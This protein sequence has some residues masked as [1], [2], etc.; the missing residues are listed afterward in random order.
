MG[1]QTGK[2]IKYAFGEIILVVIG[3]LIAL[4]IN[5]W[6]Q[7][8]KDSKEENQLL[9]KLR[10]NIQSDTTTL[11]RKIEEIQSYLDT[12]NVIESEMKDETLSFF[13]VEISRPLLS[14]VQMNL[15]TT[16]WENL[17]STGKLSLLKNGSLVDSL[18]MYYKQFEDVNKL[19]TEGFQ[20]YNRGILAPRFFELDDFTF[21]SP[22][23]IFNKE[24][25]QRLPPKKYGEN[26][27]FRNAV[28][29]RIGALKSIKNIFQTDLAK[30]I[31]M[32][33][34]LTGE[35]DK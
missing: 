9:V 14:A 25:V 7:N 3:I 30:A 12:L 11:K 26:V 2:Y 27:F 17:K 6:S 33:D 1:D 18:Q 15:E 16:T 28:R 23:L 22:E 8:N 10:V 31:A 29:Y 20:S 19:W 5:T 13:S 21:F 24:E 32:I 35:I 34:I 4:Q